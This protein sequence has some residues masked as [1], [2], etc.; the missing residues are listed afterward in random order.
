MMGGGH[1]SPRT[2]RRRKQAVQAQP[3]SQDSPVPTTPM[4]SLRLSGVSHLA[5]PWGGGGV[6]FALGG[7]GGGITSGGG[8][9]N[10]T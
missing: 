6:S 1:I 8:L 3:L 10:W 2:T 7:R 4:K 5:D 9:C